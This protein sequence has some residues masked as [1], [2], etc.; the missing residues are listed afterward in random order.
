MAI[1]MGTEIESQNTQIDRLQEKAASNET[2]I[3][4]T[5]KRVDKKLKE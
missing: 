4:L 5:T 3:E 2:R 1:D